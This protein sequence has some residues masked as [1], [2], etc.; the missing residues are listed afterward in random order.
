MMREIPIDTSVFT[1]VLVAGIRPKLR[2]A[3]GETE[4]H[5]RGD[6]RT[7][8]P[9]WVAEVLFRRSEDERSEFEEV[10]V[11]ASDRPT[12]E[13]PAQLSGLVGIPYS[14]NGNSGVSFRAD[15]ISNAGTSSGGQ[16][17]QPKEQAR[18]EAS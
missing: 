13:G 2:R 7:G 11:T 8:E 15:S 5:Q 14:F 18:S 3:E 4:F 9:Q 17:Q 10:T 6:P 12:V 1:Q 16:R